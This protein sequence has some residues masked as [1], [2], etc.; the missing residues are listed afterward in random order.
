LIRACDRKK[1]IDAN[2]DSGG[3][4]A[5]RIGRAFGLAAPVDEDART[6]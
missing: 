4:G 2:T 1:R 6:Q 3:R 5:A